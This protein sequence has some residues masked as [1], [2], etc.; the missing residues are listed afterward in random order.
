MKLSR[1]LA[2]T[3]PA[4]GVR[5]AESV[6]ARDFRMAERADAYHKLIYVLA[7]SVELREE[8]RPTI[9]V[10]AGS[11]LLLPHQLRH[12]IR[13]REPSTLLLLCL[14]AK[15]LATD[16][17]LGRLWADLANIPGRQL[18]LSRPSR[19]RLEAMWRRAM[20][21]SRVL[22]TG[23][24]LA[25][26]SLA[27]Q[28][29]ILLTRIP[30]LH[31]TDNARARVAAVL[32]EID[33]NFHDDWNLDRAAIRAGLSR[34]QFSGLFRTVAGK[35]FREHLTDQRLTHAA[36]LLEAGEHSIL[37]V[38]FSCGF[39]DVSTFYRQFQARFRLPPQAWRRRP[40]PARGKP[41][42]TLAM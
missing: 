25:V 21:E 39:N 12:A 42:P 40:R 8:G 9:E 1:P 7:G 20:V 34:R 17:D 32:R 28:I 36:Q 33:E 26:R 11:V 37:G 18:Q 13:D 15:F 2:I 14:D 3:M 41:A 6:H 19:F 5:F 30:V 29:L 16:P 27:A 4:Y 10:R 35:S 38:M 22:P 23:A 31:R 24:T